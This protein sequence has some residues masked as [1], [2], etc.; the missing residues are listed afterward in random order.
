LNFDPS[1]LITDESVYNMIFNRRQNINRT[2]NDDI[3]IPLPVFVLTKFSPAFGTEELLILDGAEY[4]IDGE[5][6]IEL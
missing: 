6:S 5:N 2:S 1:E 4:K 3:E